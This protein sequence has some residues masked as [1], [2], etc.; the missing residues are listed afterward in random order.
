M[1]EAKRFKIVFVGDGGVGKSAFI[2]RHKTGEFDKRYIPTMGVEVVPLKFKTNKGDTIFN[3][4]DTAGQE[5]FGGLRDGYYI[6]ADAFVVFFDFT[7]RLSFNSINNWMELVKA[8]E[9]GKPIILVG[10]KVDCRS[11]QVKHEDITYRPYYDISA[12]SNYQFEKP[13]LHL[14]RTLMNDDSVE[15]VQELAHPDKH[16]NGE[17]HITH[18]VSIDERFISEPCDPHR[19]GE[20]LKPLHND[21][22]SRSVSAP[23]HSDRTKDVA[24]IIDADLVGNNSSEHSNVTPEAQSNYCVIV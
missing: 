3:I 2:K 14:A 15:F 20:T 1:S 8:R 13:F 21:V 11:H 4:W 6:G 24:P 16:R 17:P 18:V 10:N 22:I 9:P 19:N 23:A 5:K 12:K 7:N